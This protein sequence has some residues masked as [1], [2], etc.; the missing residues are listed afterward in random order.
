MNYLLQPII[1]IEDSDGNP[2]VGGKVYVYDHSTQNLAVTYS[3][4]QS[5]MN[6]NPIILD[7]L[8]H[9]V[10]IAEADKLY[11][12]IVKNADDE[13]QFSII[14]ASVIGGTGDITIINP[15]VSVV[16]G[17]GI[18]VTKTPMLDGSYRYTVALSADTINHFTSIDN[19]I[20]TIEGSIIG[21]NSELTEIETDITNISNEVNI[22]GADVETLK[23]V[24]YQ[25]PLKKVNNV[26]SNNGINV[27]ASGRAAWAEGEKTKATS[28]SCHAEGIETT[29]SYVA[30]HAEGYGTES[31]NY[32]SHAEG[33]QTVAGAYGS[34]AEGKSTNAS[35]EFSHAEG[36]ETAAKQRASHASGDNTIANTDAETVIGKY[37]L[38]EAGHIFQVGIGSSTERKDAFQID[39]NGTIRYLYNNEMVQLK[40]LASSGYENK[41]ESTYTITAND[42][43]RRHFGVEFENIEDFKDWIKTGIISSPVFFDIRIIKSTF[44]APWEGAILTVERMFN[45]TSRNQLFSD[46]QIMGKSSGHLLFGNDEFTGVQGDWN[47]YISVDWNPG[48]SP[49]VQDETIRIE[50]TIQAVKLE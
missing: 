28:A 8:G 26:V 41:F 6:T 30:A 22:I 4:F 25:M 27:E 18:S 2:L 21:I 5:H 10:I 3:D 38:D 9:C 7:S 46:Y 14:N 44:S 40:P 16:A 45:H 23:N 33:V 1:Q 29:A 39:T 50:L 37:N 15:E 48:N 17:T 42:I 47:P 32:G 35:A 12:V 49:F 34:H 31:K 20:Q 13:L 11:D 36:V 19:S 24:S 43:Q